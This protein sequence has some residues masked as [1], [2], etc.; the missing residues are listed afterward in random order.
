[1][2]I[3]LDDYPVAD[4]PDNLRRQLGGAKSVR[5]T[6]EPKIE[7][8]R[9]LSEILADVARLRAEGKIKPVSTED[10]VARVRA[11]REEWDR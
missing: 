11:L 7:P 5:L 10:A 2:T 3:I 9:S 8:E 1:M 6:I 4:L